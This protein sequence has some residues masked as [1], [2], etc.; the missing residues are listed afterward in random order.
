M[1][2]TVFHKWVIKQTISKGV[3]VMRDKKLKLE[4][5]NSAHTVGGTGKGDT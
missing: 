4:D 1:D 3:G 2:H 5:L